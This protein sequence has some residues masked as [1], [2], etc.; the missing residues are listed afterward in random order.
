MGSQESDMT[1]WVS[2]SQS[3]SV[4]Y[5]PP[6]PQSPHWPLLRTYAATVTSSLIVFPV[7]MAFHLVSRLPEV[8]FLLCLSDSHSPL[9]EM[10]W[11]LKLSKPQWTW[12]LRF[13]YIYLTLFSWLSS[14]TASPTYSVTGHVYS[15]TPQR[16]CEFPETWKDSLLILC[17]FTWC[18]CCL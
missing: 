10:P 8:P 18:Y 1:K 5:Q 3:H 6:L 11:M 14:H 2:L 16:D 17:S 12:L 4:L 13:L 15:L 7:S 9:R